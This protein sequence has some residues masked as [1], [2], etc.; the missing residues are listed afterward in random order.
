MILKYITEFV[1][2]FSV[3]FFPASIQCFIII[4]DKTAIFRQ[5]S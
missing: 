2:L 4:Y 5:I 1:K 3:F